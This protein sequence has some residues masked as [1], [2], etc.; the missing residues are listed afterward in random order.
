MIS[1]NALE[2]WMHH[3]TDRLAHQNG[4]AAGNVAQL[5][6]RLQVEVKLQVPQLFEPISVISFLSDLKLSSY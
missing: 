5:T 4:E 3:L 6:R 1:S 2:Y